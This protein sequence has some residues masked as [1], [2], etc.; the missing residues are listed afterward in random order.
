MVLLEFQLDRNVLDD[1]RA[2][3][4]GTAD[5][6]A[7]QETYFLMPV[8]LKVSEAELL[9]MPPGGRGRLTSPWL[10]LPILHVAT[11]GLHKVKEA[12]ESGTSTYTLPGSGWRLRFA[13]SGQDISV[14]SE[15]S[16]QGSCARYE[17]LLQAFEHFASTVREVL[18]RETPELKEHPQWGRWLKTG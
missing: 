16:E 13:V 1:D 5:A 9:K 7:L 11:V 3:D 6:G 18:S 15:V 8:R 2:T 14:Y 10:T 17:E 12:R 4:L